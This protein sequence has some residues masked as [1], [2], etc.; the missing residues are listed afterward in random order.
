M[1]LVNRQLIAKLL[2]LMIILS[3]LSG[4][5]DLNKPDETPITLWV[6]TE[7]IPDSYGI[8]DDNPMSAVLQFLINEYETIHEG[9]TIE[10]EIL[11]S[12]DK[13]PEER[14]AR[15]SQ[16]RTEIMAGGGPDIY[17]L[18]ENGEDDAL[19]ADVTQAM[20]NGLFYD[21]SD[22]YDAD[23]SLG[24]EALV[25][26][27]MDAG[28]VG[29]ARYVLPLRYNFPVIYTTKTA[30][31]AAGLNTE[32]LSAGVNTLYDAL[33]ATGDPDWTRYAWLWDYG[34]SLCVFPEIIDYETQSVTLTAGEVAEYLRRVQALSSVEISYPFTSSWDIYATYSQYPLGDG[35]VQFQN[36]IGLSDAFLYS[37]NLDE[38]LDIA[39]VAQT[40][41]M[42]LA[43]YPLHSVDGS[44]VANITYWGAVGTG[45]KHPEV[46]YDFLRLLLLEDTQWELNRP[47]VPEGG[48]RG[49]IAAGW[50]VRTAESA[51]ALWEG[52]RERISAKADTAHDQLAQWIRRILQTA[53]VTAA[54]I[55]LIDEQIDVV[56]FGLPEED[57]FRRTL[58]SLSFSDSSEIE[59]EVL[60]QELVD[61]LRWH[62]AE[63]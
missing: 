24:K 33:A 29:N 35:V 5:D 42:E 54:D 36:N 28:T 20:Y 39:I 52:Y 40:L 19:F 26:A 8:S 18:P 32:E 27:V 41:G 12:A 59:V 16:L 4:C 6:L 2:P 34:S 58:M 57:N 9:V 43:M 62:M 45:C 22:L 7:N 49:R 23:N 15:L 48:V 47:P 1:R 21:V 53:N 63:G 14:E 55:P 31:E 30:L 61:S 51:E 37:G 11:P 60:A 25:T 10:L 38:A 56:R 44:L 50:P 13:A 17:L 46:A 3:T